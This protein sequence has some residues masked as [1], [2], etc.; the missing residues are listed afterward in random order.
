MA[1]PAD[2]K[3]KLD[4]LRDAPPLAQT[5][6]ALAVDPARGLSPDEVGTRQVR[7]GRNELSEEKPNRLRQLARKFWGLSAWMLELIAVLS[8]ALG[9]RADLV[10]SLLLLL[11]NAVISFSEERRAA[12]ALEALRSR[13]RVTARVLRMG[14]WSSLPAAELVA[15]DVIRLRAGDFVPADVQLVSGELRVDQSSL[16]GE[17]REVEVREAQPAFSGSVVRRG[18]ATAVVLRTGARTLFGRTAELVRTAKPHSHVEAVTARVVRWLFAVVGALVVL[19]AAM[20][21]VRGLPLS[22]VAPLALV[23]LMSAIPVALPVMFTVSMSFGAAEL[24]RAGVLVT[25]LDATEDAASM[26][27][28]CVDKTG[29]LTR[30]QLQLV[31]AIPLDGATETEVLR[32]AAMASQDANR[33]PIDLA[34][35][36]GARQR[37]LP[38]F[39]QLDFKPFSAD[40]RRTEAVALQDGV[41]WHAVKGALNTL[42]ALCGLTGEAA[43]SVDRRSHDS[44]GAGQRI[45]AVA[46]AR[47]GEPLR[48]VGL[49]AL[50]DPVRPDAGEL[51][52]E[53]RERGVRVLMLTGDAAPVAQRVASGLGLGSIA[54]A[55]ELRES[56]PDGATASALLTRVGGL[57]EVFPED[58]FAVVKALQAAGH[59]V[60]MTGDG[61][62]DAPALRQAEVGVAVREATDVARGA[63]SAVLTGEGLASLVQLVETG[64]GVFQRVL[65]WILCKVSRTLF[66]AS[67]VTLAYFVT[68]RF[69]ISALGMLVLTFV[70]DFPKVALATDR[71]PDAPEPQR[72]DLRR[73]LPAA[74]AVGVAMVAEAA[75]ALALAWRPLD[76]E[77]QQGLLETYSFV[78]LLGFSTFSLASL[79]ERRAFWRS[80]PSGTLSLSMVVALVAGTAAATFGLP[81][82]QALPLAWCAIALGVSAACSLTMND[83]LKVL[84]LRV[85][86]KSI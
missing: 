36:E 12:T 53:L 84:S 2:A 57:A 45:L 79:R 20:A 67:F 75:G 55:S 49:L 1:L 5:L 62:N 54:H 83:A 32:L 47:E 34:V 43:A 78:I 72:W 6:G 9:K 48:L 81:G 82:L 8:L 25:R 50:E 28:L 18:E 24:L 3:P 59:V 52:H 80:W 61:V 30:N 15:G 63:A 40:T 51:V 60:G 17:S 31:A 29:T 77:H 58:K 19:A 46:G 44:A 66:S 74:L 35:L 7:D 69:V 65:T 14:S 33:D 26:D 56:G 11:V 64:R 73:F 27:V 71:T 23:L 39:E 41:R 86:S 38:T 37:G 10:L 85:T 70:T 4:A 42:T 76:L 68:G 22:Q 13:L 21:L 16:T